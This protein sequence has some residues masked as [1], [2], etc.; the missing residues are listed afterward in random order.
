MAY[1]KPFDST[2]IVVKYR[3]FLRNTLSIVRD[4]VNLH[5]TVGDSVTCQASHKRRL[6]DS[7]ALSTCSH[8]EFLLSLFLG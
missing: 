6:N 5:L 1:H 7:E 8:R 3:L 2:S 4:S